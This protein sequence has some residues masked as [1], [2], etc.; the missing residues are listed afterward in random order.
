VTGAGLQADNNPLAL[1]RALDHGVKVIFAHCASEG[2]NRDT[3]QHTE[4]G[5]LIENFSLFTRLME[6]P[7]YYGLVFGDI[8]ALSQVKRAGPHLETLLMRTE[9]HPRLLYSSDYPLPGVIPLV[10]LRYLVKKNYITLEQ[11]HVLI[12]IRQ[13]NSLLFDFILNRHLQTQGHH[14]SP[15]VFYTRPLWTG[16]KTLKQPQERHQA[17]DHHPQ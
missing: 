10:S 15:E 3:D 17:T 12:Q 2:R 13:H 11:A 9:W 6:E 16:T 4:Q 7:R 5:P 1:R 14:F 8:S